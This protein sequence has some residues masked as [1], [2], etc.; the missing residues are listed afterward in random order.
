MMTWQAISIKPYHAPMYVAR[1]SSV[2]ATGSFNSLSA[3]NNMT[4]AGAL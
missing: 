1:P 3:E 2:Y 4:D